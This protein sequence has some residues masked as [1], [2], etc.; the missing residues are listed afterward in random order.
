MSERSER[1]LERLAVAAGERAAARLDVDRVAERVVRRLREE[2]RRGG[3]GRVARWLALAAAVV[4]VVGGGVYLRQAV[5]GSHTT[6]SPVAQ[7]PV[8]TVL[9]GLSSSELDEVLDSLV[10]AAPVSQQA[11]VSLDAL[12]EQQLEELLA[13]MEG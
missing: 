5:T 2:P 8:P 3:L 13:R 10:V 6:T 4:V 7:V 1:D 12:N 11:A 9:D